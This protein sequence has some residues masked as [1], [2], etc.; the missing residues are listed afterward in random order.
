[1]EQF[2]RINHNVNVM[3]GKACIAGTRITV[4]VILILLSE[5]TTIEEILVQYP[6][7]TEDDVVEAIQYAAWAVGVKEDVVAFA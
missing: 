5:G 1:M 7:L 3:G 4:G 6:H 2:T